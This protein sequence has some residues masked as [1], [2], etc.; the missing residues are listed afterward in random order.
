MQRDVE[1]L[2]ETELEY[3]EINRQIIEQ[4]KLLSD[5]ANEKNKAVY[6]EDMGWVWETDTAAI[7]KSQEDLNKLET[8][9]SE[10]SIDVYDSEIDE[11]EKILR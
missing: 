8:S 5:L 4:K 10:K 6:H 1:L 3:I 9:L 7:T 2:N 11:K